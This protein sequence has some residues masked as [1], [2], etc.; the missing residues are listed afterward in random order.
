MNILLVGQGAREQALI[1][2][3]L[4]SKLLTKLYTWPGNPLQHPKAIK[5]TLEKSDNFESLISFVHK[6]KIELVI[7][8]PEKPLAQGLADV[9]QKNSI[10]VWGP[11]AKAAK[12]E[13]SKSFAK[14]I[15][16]EANIPC[17][18]F[19]LADNQKSA[20]EIAQK[21][22]EQSS[23]VVIKAD[24][25]AGG[26][27]VYICKSTQEI[28]VA[29]ESLYTRFPQACKKIVIEEFLE[30][31]E[32]S[33]F[34]LIHKDQH[35]PLG[36]AVDFKRFEEKDQGLNTGGMGA[37]A[38][39]PWL[40]N[41][42]QEHV[43]KNIIEPL[44][45]VMKNSYTGFLYCGLMW[46]KHG[47]KIIEFNVRMGDPETQALAVSDQRDWLE[48]CNSLL[49]Q[50]KVTSKDYSKQQPSVAIVL[51]TKDYPFTNKSLFPCG[52]IAPNTF[53]NYESPLCFSAT[54]NKNG[55]TGSGRVLTVVGTDSHSFTKA[56][57][58]ALKKAE[59]L[60]TTWKDAYFRKDIAAKVCFEQ[61]TTGE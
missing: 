29:L 20:F 43:E 34:T 53:H 13:S 5:I 47:A 25:L 28:T 22:L 9:L 1:Y 17:A 33:F 24:G 49:E 23:A 2:K 4:Q 3:I 32:C 21:F 61:T 60:Q 10:K 7:C 42:A 31:R 48:I 6:N 50:K 36:F 8:G 11:T 59:Q 54:I 16:L 46:G 15:M 35:V 40:P 55:E 18:K 45:K 19:E 27:G 57:D 14:Q 51:S 56:R 58:S 26:K 44:L 30:G 38:P 12:L 37:Y 52:N 41:N 39:V